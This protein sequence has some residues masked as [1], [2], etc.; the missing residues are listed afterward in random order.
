MLYS[1]RRI[2]REAFHQTFEFLPGQPPRLIFV[3]GPGKSAVSEADD[4]QDK[5][6]ACPEQSFDP[7]FS[8]SAEEEKSIFVERIEIVS[9]ANN[10]GQAIDALAHVNSSDAEVAL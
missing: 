9:E 4:E 8:A 2:D 6:V 3:L 10:G 7:V 1:D 5:P